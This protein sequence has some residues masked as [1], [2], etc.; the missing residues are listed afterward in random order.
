MKISSRTF[1]RSC[2]AVGILA[3]WMAVGAQE[4]EGQTQISVEPRAGV[5]FPMGDL[6]DAGAEAGLALGAELMLTFQQNLSAYAGLQRHGFQ[7]ESDC[8][9]GGS[10]RS[11]GLGAGLKYVF[12]SPPDALIWGRGGVLFHELSSDE[13]SGDRNVGFEV[14]AGMDLP[15]ADRLS[16]SPHLGVLSHDAVG[17]DSA[18]WVNFGIGLHYHFN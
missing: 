17:G 3:A 1:V 2:L 11:S 10:L 4:L 18:T 14:S 16:L 8:D 15:V 6:S 13:V 12:P 5:T 9:L 7:C